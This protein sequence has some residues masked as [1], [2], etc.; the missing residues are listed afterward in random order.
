MERFAE[1]V[2]PLVGSPSGFTCSDPHARRA[3]PM[4]SIGPD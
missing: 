2:I 4:I 3:D 1:E